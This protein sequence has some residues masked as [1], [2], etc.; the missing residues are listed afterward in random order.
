MTADTAP[1]SLT[2]GDLLATALEERLEPATDDDEQAQGWAALIRRTLDDVLPRTAE[3]GSEHRVVR[4]VRD[5][6]D[7]PVPR[8]LASAWQRYEPFRQ[9]RD[10]DAYP[11][12]T[13]TELPLADH[14]ARS[15]V[16]PE[17]DVM[18]GGTVLATLRFEAEVTFTFEGAVL[19]IRDGRFR[20]VRA[21]TLQVAAELRFEGHTLARRE[22]D[23]EVIPGTL[24]FGP[25]GIPIDP[26]ADDPYAEPA[27]DGHVP[28]PGRGDDDP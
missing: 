19:T 20:A 26:F 21:G 22:P 1:T 16:E 17:V 23:H 28:A 8:L 13:E 5:A 24:E 4:M 25:D 14:V 7:V 27:T 6:M 9:Y 2:L 11:P 3:D 15:V 10:V 12:G 18:A